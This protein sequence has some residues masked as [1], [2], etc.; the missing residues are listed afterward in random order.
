MG[1]EGTYIVVAIVCVGVGMLVVVMQYALT[2]V[3][4]WVK[5]ALHNTCCTCIPTS[6]VL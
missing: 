3:V 1:M 6:P 2:V 5:V 4:V